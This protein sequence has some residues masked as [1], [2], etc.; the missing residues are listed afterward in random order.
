MPGAGIGL[1]IVSRIVELC[2]GR[3]S[4]ARSA[5][6]GLAVTL[7]LREAGGK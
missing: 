3:V 1:S 2:G 7:H 6:G 5:D 4:F